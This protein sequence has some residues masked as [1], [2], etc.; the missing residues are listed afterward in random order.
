MAIS[1]IIGRSYDLVGSIGVGAGLATD[2]EVADI[3]GFFGYC[4]R[5]GFLG[6][7]ATLLH[8][9]WNAVKSL[10]GQSDWQRAERALISVVHKGIDAF[11]PEEAKLL[12]KASIGN[13]IPSEVADRMVEGLNLINEHVKK[14]E[15]AALPIFEQLLPTINGQKIG[16]DLANGV[17]PMPLIGMFQSEEVPVGQKIDEALQYAVDH[18]YISPEGKAIVDQLPELMAQIAAAQH[19]E[20]V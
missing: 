19:P 8:R 2:Q 5:E 16:L 10:F 4:E 20:I 12:A 13:G 18:E 6:S 9:V 1:P 17:V 11:A 15:A 7:I 3:K 14:A